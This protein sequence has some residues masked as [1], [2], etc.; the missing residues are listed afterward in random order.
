[1]AAVQE[2]M[3]ELDAVRVVEGA[4]VAMCA[5]VTLYVIMAGRRRARAERVE[6]A[7]RAAAKASSGGN[8]PAVLA[9]GTAN[10]PHEWPAESYT[11][12]IENI[13]T[14]VVSEDHIS[15]F[16]R[17][18][19]NSGI[20]SRNTCIA[21]DDFSPE[22]IAKPVGERKG[23]LAGAKQIFNP[24]AGERAKVWEKMAPL[25]A[26][27]AARK[28][29][30]N[31]GG[32]KQRIT[33]VVF[34]SCTGF[35]APGV[36]LDVVDGLG[37]E[38]VK[39]RC[40]INYMGCFGGFT[41]LAVSKAFVDAD[42]DA[43]VLLVCV[44]LCSVHFSLSEVRS[45][46]I[47]N[48]IFADG[49][50][51]VVIGRGGPGD[52]AISSQNTTTLTAGSRKDMT[53]A[54]TDHSYEMFLSKNISGSLGKALF[55]NWKSLMANVCG[56]EDVKEVEWCVH[57]GGKAILEAFSNPTFG[58]GLSKH[59]LRHSYNIMEKHGNMS[60][61]TI[62]FVLNHL[63]NDKSVDKER[64][65]MLGFGPGLTIETAGLAKIKA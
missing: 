29:V 47:G 19:A 4:V 8:V 11:S 9:I 58:V 56:T 30:K 38:N 60:S 54:A 50:A 25:L 45:E 37:L 51:A 22:N 39:R 12:V 57:P 52:W 7:R 59:D 13:L 63:L 61:P 6:A 65:F 40:G 41:G 46:F 15:F 14:G 48:A 24:T 49:G 43:I 17:L 26:V 34:H 23:L 18:N 42:P 2:M 20:K 28:A 32:D 31:W 21:H 44:E 35:K 16:K 5:V 53:W 10:P 64:I 33:H 1:M 27:E 62:F 55:M 36:E 3:G